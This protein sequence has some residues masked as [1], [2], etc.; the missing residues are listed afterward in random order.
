[1]VV[2][3]DA[4]A[5]RIKKLSREQLMLLAL[6]N[7]QQSQEDDSIA[8]VGMSCRFPKG[9]N[10][11]QGYWNNLINGVDCIT[12]VIKARWKDESLYDPDPETPG[13][14]YARHAALLDDY[15]SFDAGFFG[16]SPMEADALDP[17]QRLLLEVTWEALENAGISADQI[18]GGNGGV[19]VGLMNHDYAQVVMRDPA[20]THA[21]VSMGN[22]HSTASGRLSYYLG[23]K[24][25]CVSIDT[26]CSS[27]LVSVHL[28]VQ[29]LRNREC[30]WALAGGASMILHPMTTLLSCKATMLSPTGKCHTFDAAADGYVRGEGCGILILKRLRDALRDNDRIVGVIKGSAINQDG[31]S[32]GLTAPNGP[33]QQQV[34]RL[35]LKDAKLTA[36][37]VDYVECHGTGTALGDPIEVQSLQAVYGREHVQ[38]PLWIGS[39]KTNIGHTESAAGAG[40][41]IKLLL[42]LEHQQIPPHL[43]FINPNSHIDWPH[44]N[45]KV[46]TDGMPWPRT[47]RARYGAVSSF[48]F[49]GTNAHL[50][51]Q[52]APL[53]EQ[54]SNS[55]E[56]PLH[57][58]VLSAKSEPAL[59]ALAQR[60]VDFLDTTTAALA[61][62]CY[63]AATGRAHFAWR[64]AI[65]C[66]DVA[67]LRAALAERA[68]GTSP[69]TES[70]AA[71]ALAF[72]FTGQGAQY[73]GMGQRLYASQ[74]VFQAALDE[75]AQALAPHLPMPLLSLLWGDASTHLSQ[76]QF[77]QPALFA[78][79]YA[80]AR[81]WLHMGVQP[82]VLL[83]HSVGEYAAAVIAEVMSLPDAATL[84]AAR[85][86]L[87][88]ELTTPGAMLAV[89]ATAEAM[90][91][92]LARYPHDT[93]LAAHNS[94]ASVVLSGSH[95]ALAA[96]E[97]QLNEDG[98]FCKRL[99]V[100][101]AFHSPL[102]TPMLE[103]FRAV[104]ANIVYRVPRLPMVSTLTGEVI[105]QFSAEYWVA[106]VR[107]AVQFA[108]ALQAAQQHYPFAIALEVGPGSTLA[109]LCGQNGVGERAAIPSLRNGHDEWQTLS[110]ALARLYTEGV[111]LH[112]RNVDSAYVRNKV[113]LPTYAFQRKAHWFGEENFSL[114]LQPEAAQ[115][116]YQVVWQPLL[117]PAMVAPSPE[118]LGYMQIVSRDAVLL[119]KAQQVLSAQGFAV[120]TTLMTTHDSDNLW[121]TTVR[122]WDGACR[123]MLFLGLGAGLGVGLGAGLGAD[124][125]D[126]ESLT[127]DN[128]QDFAGCLTALAQ[129]GRTLKVWLVTENVQPVGST[130]NERSLV[131]SAL[132]G[133]AKVLAL[134]HPELWGCTV[135]V[136]KAADVADWLRQ[137]LQEIAAA[138]PEDLVAYRGGRRHVPRL[139]KTPEVALVQP[140]I[141]PQATYVITGGL[142]GLGLA[143]A[144]QLVEA[145]ATR[146]VLMSRNGLSAG[147]D[148]MR[149]QQVAR[150]REQQVHVLTPAVDVTDAAALLQL[151]N[152]LQAEGHCIKGILHAAGISEFRAIRDMT[153]DALDRVLAAK[154]SG[155]FNLDRFADDLPLDFFVLFSSIAAIWGSAGELHY[156]AA[157]HVL[158]TFAAWRRQQGKPVTSIAWGPWGE[159]GMA[160]AHASEATQ[161]GLLLMPPEQAAHTCLQLVSHG[162]PHIVVANIDW[163]R[164]REL[165][166][167]AKPRPFFTGLG[168]TAET[169]E[170]TTSGKNNART[171]LTRELASLAPETRS[172]RIKHFVQHLVASSL[173]L[174]ST[175]AI[176]PEQ[177]L[178]ALGIDSLMAVEMRRSLEK[179]FGSKFPSTLIFDY[180]TIE[181]ITR[182]IEQSAFGNAGV[183]QQQRALSHF[184]E[185]IAI[186]G[187]SCRYP[188]YGESAESFWHHLLQGTDGI[189]DSPA[190][191]PL[192]DF[193]ALLPVQGDF[194][195]HA[196][197]LEQ[198]EHF[199]ADLFGISPREARAMDPQQRIMLETAW[200]ALEH[201]GFSPLQL[202]QSRTGVFVGVADNEYASLAQTARNIDSVHLPTGNAVNVISGRIAYTFGL[203]GPCMAIDTACSSSMVAIHTACQSLRNDECDMALA[204]GVNIMIR[205]ET[206][207]ML[208]Q[209]NMLS[210]SGRCHTFDSQADGYVRSEGAAVLVLKRLS[211][212][213]ENNDNIVGI[214]RGSAVNQDG[215]SSSLTAPNG[216]SQQRVIQA[217]LAQ[218]QLTP[219]DVDYLDAHGTG[220]TLGDPIELQAIDAVYGAA[221]DSK[222]PLIVGSV[223]TNIGHAESAAGV[224]SLIKVMLSLQHDT[225]P[226]HLHLQ[227]INPHIDADFSR[228]HIPA[229]AMPWPRTERARYGAVSSFGFSGTNA[230]LILQEA[231]LREQVSNSVERPLHV[232]V[233]SAKSE[234]ALRALAQRYVDF[235]DTT[236]AALADIC[237]TAATGRAHFAWRIAIPCQDVAQLRAALA[238]RAAGTSPLTESVAAPA[239]AFLFTGQG[240]QYAGMGQRL[241]ASQPVFQAALDEAAQA[242]APHLPMPLLSLLW[243]DAST[244]LSQTQFTQPALFALEY[245]LARLW[246]HMGVQP[247][248]L[249]GH[250]VGEYAA[251]VIA[252][253]MSLPDA[254]TLIA[255]RGRL[256]VELTT[257][258]AMLA[259]V[260][261]AEAMAPYLARYPHDTALAAHNSPASV[262]L[263]GSHAA[264][265]ALEQ[266]L[267]ED[268]Y[269]CKRLN[270]SHAFHSPLMTPMLEAFRAV[271]AN[272]VYRVPRLPMVSTLTGEVIEQFSAEYWVAH[273]RDAVQ[274]A[275]ALQAA[276]Q[277]YPF[278]IA[279]EVGPGST[280]AGL[281]GQNGVG[282]RAAIPSLRNGHDEWQTL[283]D[284]LARLYT[285][286][287]SLHW[288]NVDSAYARNK[289]ALPTYAFQRERYWLHEDSFLGRLQQR[290]RRSVG[291]HPVLGASLALPGSQERRYEQRYSDHYPFAIHD[292]RIYGTPLLPG[293]AH[294]AACITLAR[295][296][297]AWP[298]VQISN[299]AI[300]APLA[301]PDAGEATVQYVLQPNAL[302]FKAQCFA[303]S[304]Q[305]PSTWGELFRAELQPMATPINTEHVI[306]LQELQEK[307]LHRIDGAT[308]YAAMQDAGY[309]WQNDFQCIE[310]LWAGENQALARLRWPATSH[311]Y[312]LPPGLIDS[313]L[314]TQAATRLSALDQNET[315]V[316]IPVGCESI[317]VPTV[318]VLPQTLWCH[319][320]LR[321]Q[322]RQSLVQD[323]TVYD[324]QGRVLIQLLGLVSRRAPRQ[325]LQTGGN[326]SSARPL[327]RQ[328]WRVATATPHADTIPNAQYLILADEGQVAEQLSLALASRGITPILVRR[329]E[330][331]PTH[332]P[333]RLHQLHAT[334]DAAMPL[335]VL[336]L[337]ALDSVPA[338]Q[339][340]A[341]LLEQE[342]ASLTL[343]SLHLYQWLNTLRQPVACLF[344]TQGVSGPLDASPNRLTGSLL[345]GMN[346]VMALE[347]PQLR[348]KTLDLSADSDP[349]H[350]L[351]EFADNQAEHK[352]A[353]RGS[354]RWVARL[355]RAAAPAVQAAVSIRN[356]Q[357]YLITGG[358]GALGLL[359]ARWLADNGAEHLALL[360]RRTPTAAE[361]RQIDALQ[362]QGV[363]LYLLKADIAEPTSLHDA[364]ETLRSM[365]PPLAGVLHTA[366]V[367]R[368]GV[369]AQQSEQDF[370]AV[371]PPKVIGT[372]LLHQML[373]TTPLDFFVTFSSTA[374][375]WGS[376]GQGN[377]AAA[378]QFMDSLCRWRQRQGWVATSINWGPWKEVGMAANGA[379]EQRFADMALSPAQGLNAF[380][381]LLQGLPV[382]QGVMQIS[383][384]A[385]QSTLQAVQH[386][387]FYQGLHAGAH[388]DQ[389]AA[390]RL[391]E[392][393]AALRPE[394][395]EAAMLNEL[396]E[397]VAQVLRTDKQRIKPSHALTE[398]GL[399]SLMA[400]ELRNQISQWMG[401]PLPA[402]LLFDYP[403]LHGITGY[404]LAEMF[405]TTV[406]EPRVEPT[407]T[408][409]ALALVENMSDDELAALLESMDELA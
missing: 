11:P 362:E 319:A 232:F 382:Q 305:T 37:D 231:P 285:E 244:H 42:S 140:A 237:Y 79:E 25:P 340:T 109:G 134:E 302:G 333:E 227:Q 388:I 265:A 117:L 243:G 217:A 368:D 215:R 392:R 291:D 405:P 298:S 154:L 282:E 26:A 323:L 262:V 240:A 256:M 180:P 196:G 409:D 179:S 107:D 209:A 343:S 289:V 49:S 171:A 167:I 120:G 114:N 136:D 17:Q 317:I 210:P 82:R 57:V 1:M 169:P 304:D 251:A 336:H 311:G 313:I 208:T 91:P 29:S 321:Q 366:G 326:D 355:I 225:L 203:E 220:T 280:L 89:V 100:S 105:E 90:A 99:N 248:V 264:L 385:L 290:G 329:H 23:I 8:V 16:I 67:Q 296:E 55:V 228:L 315:D 373:A 151:K 375:L 397:Q 224:A 345:W 125:K 259:V 76:T 141:D 28:A 356:D 344:V 60:Y 394:Q 271:A 198:I 187:V 113:A 50:I 294:I 393:M 78:L 389:K 358:L 192:Q 261:T 390:V 165:I 350:M 41:L 54:V 5:E 147:T 75:A 376:P 104:A 206:F 219:A 236:T 63:T 188:G 279:L 51:L 286:G 258:G 13:K 372:W 400:V 263:S 20:R 406:D 52:E 402:T 46:L 363:N 391:R 163:Q 24:G 30:E 127:R 387:P 292:H 230:H 64:I 348:I 342:Q 242:L 38:R 3:M 281:C 70:V 126:A 395:R 121:A 173:N 150:W 239:L 19:F 314:Q 172:T 238:E 36:A 133:M 218:A 270:V 386:L 177:P 101:H 255:A 234:P 124:G 359:F 122:E 174:D 334:L 88:V 92:Y 7:H 189:S 335:H 260:A 312:T 408:D 202:K 145:G 354:E 322:D 276:Q 371:M 250:S 139:V 59:R 197:L 138:A 178:H 103:A 130:L 229:Q 157:N 94:P 384:Q 34:I 297:L 274:F 10:D 370:M 266:Q 328:D 2:D 320:C 309:Q 43:N 383:D 338:E 97:Q 284:A 153:H 199:D 69:L 39:A 182:Y 249:L 108:P 399:D 374:S 351:N 111:T 53:R 277:H 80:L 132:P 310:Q 62:I 32:Q 129:S 68:A 9:G 144:Q 6:R 287:V 200:A 211:A 128:A 61:D 235:L 85:G 193:K 337:W 15:K 226:R 156:A 131:Q 301:F 361:Q 252:E 14:I 325:L 332:L 18:Y 352:I 272:I 86:R 185:P 247:R 195:I 268:G 155:T 353:L 295:D 73:A 149:G 33:S 4:F 216:P 96:L 316:F 213:L 380:A 293:A 45:V 204:G 349:I 190:R 364:L 159:V 273:V 379:I 275:P 137:V 112:W 377:Y 330:Q 118:A 245:A 357:T 403:T 65:P 191:W 152:Q 110:D 72:L 48:G 346:K 119:H 401:K 201:A 175:D 123:H 308:F 257:P 22:A 116:L 77:T 186:I 246:L 324:D 35:A 21:F 233:L 176:D 143:L 27:S 44:C 404:L 74:P 307:A 341:E 166:E 106:H 40:G 194:S 396:V 253:V 318:T 300:V 381:N 267:N 164:F 222:H 278:A 102:M 142:G 146:L 254:A 407:A 161:R 47:E 367:L 160:A 207:F 303:A 95:A 93:A 71:P 148:D 241:Y 288:R 214:I 84:I 221:H 360:A 31:H 269:F 212:A 181:G 365:M 12:D 283:S 83:G 56:R 339:L 115:W 81:L 87:M 327:F 135:D 378:N 306:A 347:S 331:T 98:Y 58:F 158:D 369:L 205:P 299:V 66:Q 162:G 398:L 184:Q 168:E 170:N 183:Q 223:K